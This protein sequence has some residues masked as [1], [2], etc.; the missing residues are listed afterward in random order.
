MGRNSNAS[1]AF[2]S[3]FSR[4]MSLTSIQKR[5]DLC[6]RKPN[7]KKSKEI[8]KCLS[9]LLVSKRQE[10]K[11]LY[12]L[13]LAQNE[14]EEL[15]GAS[16]IKLRNQNSLSSNF[17]TQEPNRRTYFNEFFGL[18][19]N[20]AVGQRVS[21]GVD[22]VP[23]GIRESTTFDWGDLLTGKAYLKCSAALVKPILVATFTLNFSILC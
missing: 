20:A 12:E 4:G 13:Q 2:R 23:L 6:S 7:R 22:K 16:R 5:K 3:S 14:P 21:V 8:K 15:Q 19:V 18:E 1:K 10:T 9:S 11:R 17:Q